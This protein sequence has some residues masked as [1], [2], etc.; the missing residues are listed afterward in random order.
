MNAVIWDY[1][2]E[3]MTRTIQMEEY[4]N[5]GQISTNFCE[6]ISEVSEVLRM[7]EM[8]KL[9]ENRGA[10]LIRGTRTIH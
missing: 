2:E 10:F 3:M 4:F 6:L 9:I 5:T 1:Y 8:E 7:M